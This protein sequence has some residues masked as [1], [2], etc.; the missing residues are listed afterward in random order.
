MAWYIEFMNEKEIMNET[1]INQLRRHSLHSLKHNQ[2]LEKALRQ[3]NKQNRQ[4]EN[5]LHK[6]QQRLLQLEARLQ[7]LQKEDEA[8]NSKENDEQLEI[9]KKMTF[10]KSSEKRP[11]QTENAR[12]RLTEKVLLHAQKLF[13]APK[14]KKGCKI[15]KI[16]HEHTLTVE[17][18]ADIAESYGYPRDSEWEEMRITDTSQEYD[19]QEVKYVRQVH[20]IRK[21]RLKLSKGSGR[22]IIVTANVPPKLQKG[23]SYSIGIAVQAVCQKFLY[24][25]PLERQRRMMEEQGLDVRVRTLYNLQAIAAQRLVSVA[26][27]IRHDVLSQKNLAVHMDETPWPI[28]DKNQKKGY[29]WVMSNQGGSVY[30]FAPTRS[31]VTAKE[32][33]GSYEGPLV[34]D[35]YAGYNQLQK[36]AAIVLAHCWAHARRKFIQIEEVYPEACKEILDLMG[37][38]FAIEEQAENYERLKILRATKSAEVLKKLKM[39]LCRWRS[40]ARPESALYKAIN[41]VH[42]HWGGLSVFSDD[43]RVPLTNNDAERTIRQSVMGRK[44]FYGSKTHKGAHT[45]SV[46]YTIIESCKKVELKPENYLTYALTEKAK[47]NTPLT[48][49]KYAQKIR[50]NKS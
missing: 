47:N 34:V 38:L 35:G 12:P 25:M 42:K 29:M 46:A 11:L 31:G 30:H 39:A 14:E 2:N 5:F 15:E 48:P 36:D 41:Y 43:V 3:S 19:I 40:T 16:P 28:F 8:V 32:L 45:A 50:Q 6:V 33:L 9:L 10:G 22:E 44:N 27:Q 13:P 23:C 4:L 18:L 20:K 49:L 24:H 1:D 7:E 21:Y 17:E 37:Q 26:K